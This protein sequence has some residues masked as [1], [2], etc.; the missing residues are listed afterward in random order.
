[1]IEEEPVLEEEA[2]EDGI[3]EAQKLEIDDKMG[4]KV[5]FFTAS[6]NLDNHLI[7]LK[8]KSLRGLEANLIYH[9]ALL[10]FYR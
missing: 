4:A 1:M 7:F 5:L 9:S 3:P 6:K 10:Q 8:K 2:E